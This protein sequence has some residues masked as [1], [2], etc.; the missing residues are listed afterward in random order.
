MSLR[1]YNT[2]TQQLE[3]F[4]PLHDNVVR[5]YTCGPTVYNYAHI[6]NFRSF[7]FPDILRR[8]LRARGYQLDHV[9]NITDIEDKIIRD[10]KAAGKSIDEFTAVYTKAFLEDTA[11]LRLE[12][13]ERIV[14]ATQHIPEM[15]EAVQHLTERGHTYV[16]DGSVYY[17]ISTFPEYGKL[18]HNDFSG[19]RAGARVD[20]DEYDKDDARDF[21]LW[22]AAKE[23][24]P[25]WDTPVGKGRPGWHIEC[26]AMAMKYLGDTLDIHTG[27]VDLTFPHHENEIAQAEGITGKQFV[28]FWLHAEHLSVD[29]QKMSKSLGNIY[30]LRDLKER[31]FAPEALRYLLASVPYRKKLNFTFYGLQA[32]TASIERLRNIK[33]RLET[34]TFPDGVDDEIARR[35]QQ[36]VNTFDAA[37]DDDLNTAEALAAVFFYVRDANTA[38]DAGQFRK[39]NVTAGLEFLDR[40]DSIFDV[41]KPTAH[42]GGL[43]DA[44]VDELIAERATAKKARNF[45]RS[46]EIRAQLASQGVILEDTKEGVRWKRS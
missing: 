24:E 20:V 38:M 3:E 7:V 5:M 4:K 31:G 40:F 23:G 33:L 22:K 28:R 25:A 2:L 44:E 36:E 12:R 14:P 32:A 15:V 41:L 43:S 35:T 11:T 34:G 27:G 29:S 39:G 45:G 8:W 13:P 9:M 46:D 1:F 16:S 10:S 37:L 18:S 17:R 30:T 21:V 19:V 26:S 42:A 6:G